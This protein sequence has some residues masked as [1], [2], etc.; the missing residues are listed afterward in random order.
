MAWPHPCTEASA[1]SGHAPCGGAKIASAAT[2]GHGVGRGSRVSLS[3]HEQ[4]AL[5]RLE[6]ALYQQDPDF[7]HRVRSETVLL[8]AR[9]RL[10]LSVLGFVVGLGLLLAFCLTTSVVVGVTGF[11][12]MF[13]CLDTLW[14]NKRRM[15]EARLDDAARSALTKGGGDPDTRHRHRFPHQR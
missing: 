11:L 10:T 8:Y 3:E 5:D 12:I 1:P 6:Q 9:R 13:V 2:L 15:G 4:R 14:T 7:A